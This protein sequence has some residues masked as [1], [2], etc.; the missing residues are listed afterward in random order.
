MKLNFMRVS[1]NFYT[2]LKHQKILQFSDVFRGHKIALKSPKKLHFT[3][4][5][6][7]KSKPRISR[8]TFTHCVKSAQIRSFSGPNAGKY[9]PEKTPY[10]DAVIAQKTL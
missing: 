3:K 4:F 6:H 5:T 1:D 8:A 9:G 2:P 10:L 7:Q